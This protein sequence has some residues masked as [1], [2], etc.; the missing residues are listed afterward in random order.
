MAASP[1]QLQEPSRWHSPSAE[2]LETLAWGAAALEAVPWGRPALT[3]PVCL[4]SSAWVGLWRPSQTDTLIGLLSYV[5]AEDAR[6]WSMCDRQDG[7]HVSSIDQEFRLWTQPQW[8]RSDYLW[9][10]CEVLATYIPDPASG[11]D[12]APVSDPL[13]NGFS[14]CRGKP[15]Q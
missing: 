3:W 4:L 9:R 1:I 12:A 14:I 8:H 10:M 13:P 5:A 6:G 7:L 2:A 11:A 15:L